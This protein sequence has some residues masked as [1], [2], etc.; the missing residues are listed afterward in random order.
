MDQVILSVVDRV[1][2]L[3]AADGGRLSVVEQQGDA[4]VLR[5]QPGMSKDCPECVLGD[6]AVAMLVQEAL[7][8]QVPYIKQVRLVS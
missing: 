1:N 4:L 7:E 3:L 2:M 5:Y 6:D 8:L